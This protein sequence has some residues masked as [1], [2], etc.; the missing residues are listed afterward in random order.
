MNAPKNLW[1]FLVGIGVPI[2][3]LLLPAETFML[4]DI[5]VLEHRLLAIF[6]TCCSGFWVVI[7]VFAHRSPLSPLNC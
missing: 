3:I 2:L 7:P 1:K 5:T 4:G 6:G